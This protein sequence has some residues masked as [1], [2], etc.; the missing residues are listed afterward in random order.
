MANH[1]KCEWC[2]KRKAVTTMKLPD[3]NARLN[4]CH[5][6]KANPFGGKKQ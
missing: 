4:V 1:L 6:C 5:E 2:N 3:S